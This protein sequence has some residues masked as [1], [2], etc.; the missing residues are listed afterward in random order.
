MTNKI[1]LDN[2]CHLHRDPNKG[3]AISTNEKK[4]YWE[5]GRP[6]NDSYGY[7]S[8]SFDSRETAEERIDKGITDDFIHY[9][10]SWCFLL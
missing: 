5:H 4:E 1:Y 6:V 8:Y 3:P 9:R 7:S 10:S 2:S